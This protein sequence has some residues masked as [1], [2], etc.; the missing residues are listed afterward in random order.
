MNDQNDISPAISVPDGPSPVTIKKDSSGGLNCKQFAPFRLQEKGGLEK[1][2]W[3]QLSAIFLLVILATYLVKDNFFLWDTVQ[4]ASAQAQWFFDNN[5]KDL[6]LPAWT[7][8]GHPPSFGIYLA[9]VWKIFGKSLPVSHFAMVPFLC[10]VVFQ[11]Y[12]L[13][14]KFFGKPFVIYGFLVLLLEPTILTQGI[15]VSPDIVLLFFFL[16]SLNS[17]LSGQRALLALSLVFLAMIS[18]RGMMHVAALFAME[19]VLYFY[20]QRN[21]NVKNIFNLG[22]PYVPTGLLAGTWLLLHYLHTGWIG[23]YPDSPWAESFERVDSLGFV[24]NIFILGW[25]LADFGRIFIWLLAVPVIYQSF[26][27]KKFDSKSL[28]LVSAFSALFLLITP[29][30]VLHTSLLAHRYLLVVYLLFSLFVLYQLQEVFSKHFKALCLFLTAGLVTGNLWVYPDTVATGW[31]STLA[32]IP[33]YEQRNKMLDFIKENNISPSDVGTA[34]PNNRSV[35]DLDLSSESWN[36]PGKDLEKNTYIF[37]SNYING[38]SDEELERLKSWE[39]VKEFH[40]Y[41]VKTILYKKPE[42]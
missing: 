24:K 14:R 26:S 42:E 3:L 15:L 32:H 39:K 19:M 8:S 11:L 29:N 27:R 35:K 30:L 28:V 16:L 2:E 7:D 40:S 25:R 37:Y 12:L 22:L 5:F 1:P 33:F 23:Y 6:Y 10:G 17:I 20:Y 31:D 38:F 34:F 4:L 36:F 18:M 9:A 41:T 13:A 21:F